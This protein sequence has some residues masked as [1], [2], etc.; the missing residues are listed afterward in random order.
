MRKRIKSA[1]RIEDRDFPMYLIGCVFLLLVGG[2]VVVA[3]IT[4]IRTQESLSSS[5]D[6]MVIFQKDAKGYGVTWASGMGVLEW[7]TLG[8]IHMHGGG[9]SIE[10]LDSVSGNKVVVAGPYAIYP[11]PVK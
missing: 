10:F 5:S 8:P 1:L 3:N 4:P 2:S 6:S 11:A 7:R 9:S